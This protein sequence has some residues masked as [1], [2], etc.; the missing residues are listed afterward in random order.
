MGIKSEKGQ[1]IVFGL[2]FL[3]VVVMSL[4][5]IYNQGQLVNHR[6]QLENTADA[7]VYS[8]AKLAARNQNFIAYTNRAMVANEVS[9]GQM[10]AL[11]SWAKHYKNT[12]A[13]VNYPLYKF[14]VAPPSPTTFSDVLNVVTLPYKLLGTAAT[15]VIKVMVETWPTVVSVFNGVLGVFQKVFALA[16][17][18]AQVEINLDV[19]SDHERD[20]DNPEMYIPV[21]GWFFFTQ[22]ALL[23]YFGENFSSDTLVEKVDE[24]ANY[25][26]WA[27]DGQE[28]AEDFL[29]GQSLDGIENMISDNSPG[30]SSKKSKN[31]GGLTDTGDAAESQAVESYQRYA[32]IVNRNRESFTEDRHWDLWET[33]P[34]LVPDIT[35]ALGIVKLTIELDFTVGFGIKNDGGTAYVAKDAVESDDDIAKLGWSSMDVTSFGVEFDVSLVVEVEVCILGCNSWTL[36]DIAFNIPIGFPLAGA[37]H[38]LVSDNTYAKTTFAEW[39]TLGDEDTGM[40]GGDPDDTD[41]DGALDFFHLQTILYGQIA[42][43]LLPGMYG[44]NKT[45]DVTDSYGAPP[46]FFSLGA[47]FQEQARSY[48]YSIA[49]A[50]IFDDIHTT[51]SSVFDIGSSQNQGDWDGGV[52]DNNMYDR[53]ELTT[54]SRAEAGDFSGE[55]QQV[56]WGDDRPMMTVSSAET[57]FKNPM[58][59]NDDGSSEPASLFS[60]F[61]DARLREPSAV[62]L[63][64]A[65]GEVDFSDFISDTAVGMVHWLLDEIGDKMVETGVDYLMDQIGSP[66]DGIFEDPV[67]D[68][69]TS[70]KDTAV[71]AIV[72]ELTE[73][74][75]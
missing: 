35:I 59:F 54:Q 69:A 4:L 21:I 70:V 7:A 25:F 15:P 46:S 73:F 60:P 8:Q 14:P 49:V 20:P 24:A 37:T 75:D 19:L 56:I 1:A 38:Q 23:T 5:I 13:F 39:G 53:F 12:G 74:M 31:S 26:D 62:V 3:A 34:D 64:L 63:L 11:L 42:P 57:Y 9:I 51:D 22:N 2:L 50:K 72:D 43:E 33:T 32:A 45:D 36:I 66:A 71:D 17:L 29:I 10:V 16:T 68:A 6:V 30:I 27:A 48:E 41:N 52:D 67:T 47:N 58:Q 40:Y 65:T 28:L 55:Y 44:A 18:E 61:W